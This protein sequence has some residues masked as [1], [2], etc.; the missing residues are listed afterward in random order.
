MTRHCRYAIMLTGGDHL[1]PED[2]DDATMMARERRR[3][4]AAAC[5]PQTEPLSALH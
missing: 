1:C 4:N 3:L 5:A 2:D